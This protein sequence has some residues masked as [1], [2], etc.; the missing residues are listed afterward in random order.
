MH[1]CRH[2]MECPKSIFQTTECNLPVT[3]PTTDKTKKPTH[4]MSKKIITFFVVVVM[5]DFKS[6]EIFIKS[7]SKK[8]K[9]PSEIS[10]R[11]VGFGACLKKKKT[12]G[13]R[14]KIDLGYSISA[15]K[16]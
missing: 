11:K 6:S 2:E 8:N 7:Y 14:E 3:N 13:E 4:Y 15:C 12:M 1:I 16:L 10:F 9:H 5:F